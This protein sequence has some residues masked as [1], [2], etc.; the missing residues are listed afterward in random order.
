MAASKSH[1]Y[2][3]HRVVF[4]VPCATLTG[5]FHPIPV[6][7]LHFNKSLQ[8]SRHEYE[9]HMRL[10]NRFTRTAPAVDKSATQS[11]DKEQAPQDVLS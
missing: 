9:H 10:L 3:E 4:A 11:M 5:I 1:V 8:R 7:V 6:L 2:I